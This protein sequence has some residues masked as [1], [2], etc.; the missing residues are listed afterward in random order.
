MY[1]DQWAMVNGTR[2]AHPIVL[3]ARKKAAEG[4]LRLQIKFHV[5]CR[6]AETIRSDIA[7]MLNLL[8]PTAAGTR[9]VQ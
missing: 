3:A 7:V 8:F 1:T 5:A 2:I 4:V 9:P 6:K